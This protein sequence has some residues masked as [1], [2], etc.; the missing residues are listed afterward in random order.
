MEVISVGEMLID[1]TP[2]KEANS[3]VR[4]P[5]GA[6]ANAI[7]AIAR[8]GIS[9]GFIGKLGDDDFGR[10]LKETL[11]KEN[12]KVLCPE[13]CKEAITTLAFVTL[14]ENGERSFTFARKPG[15]DM[16]LSK[17][18][19]D[20]EAIKNAKVVHAGTVNMTLEPARGANIFALKTAKE[21]GKLVSFDINYRNALWESEEACK[22][23]ADQVYEYVDFLKV[24]DEELYFVGGEENIPAFMEKYNIAV[25]VET[26]GADGAKY[27]FNGNSKKV[28]GHK[29]KAVDATG[30]G[31][32]FWG[33]FIARL[34]MN[35][36]VSVEDL[37]EEKIY[38]AL[39][40]GNAAGAVCVQRMGGIPAL[41]T[42][43]EIESYLA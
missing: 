20:V 11:E 7:I 30:A 32:A 39:E 31:D 21:N 42:K 4:N 37:T 28:D 10:F 24:S 29:V 43:E 23:V 18:D 19:I 36:V 17:E 25:V 5:G 15:A 38:K 35:G 1:F 2:G 14:Y 26:L 13:L 22:E 9:T 41:P 27:F 40:Y 3:Y 8:N 34:L 12:V 6:P 16:L 33:G